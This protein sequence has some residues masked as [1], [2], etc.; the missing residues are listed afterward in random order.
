MHGQRL[1][2]PVTHL[3]RHCLDLAHGAS[4]QHHGRSGI[5]EG[6]G[7]R[8]ANAPPRPSDETDLTLQRSRTHSCSF[9][10]RLKPSNRTACEHQTG[11]TTR[12]DVI[13]TCNRTI[14]VT[15]GID[16]RRRPMTTNL[17]DVGELNGELP[18]VDQEPQ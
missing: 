13:D 18:A 11:E 12:D 5:G 3:C 10:G 2:A 6:E 1:A 17:R 15:G 9:R 8:F 14:S 4:P 7:S 16:E